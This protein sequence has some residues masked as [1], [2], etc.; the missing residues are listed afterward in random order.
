MLLLAWTAELSACAQEAGYGRSLDLM[1]ER[2]TEDSFLHWKEAFEVTS[3]DCHEKSGFDN[4][5]RSRLFDLMRSGNS[6]AVQVG[7][8]SFHCLDGGE[9]EDFYRSAG[10][11]FDKNPD[12]LMRIVHAYPVSGSALEH[13]V[14]ML[15]LETVDDIDGRIVLI[16]KRIGALQRL[17]SQPSHSVSQR[18]I[19]ALEEYKARLEQMNVR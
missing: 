4:E 6:Y 15:P 13:M 19:W 17:S 9:L 18:L 14:T 1:L 7:V 5:K 11:F 16:E 8:M 10:S 2:P 12:E 3:D